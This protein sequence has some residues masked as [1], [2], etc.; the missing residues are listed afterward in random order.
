MVWITEDCKQPHTMKPSKLC[1]KRHF[2]EKWLDLTRASSLLCVVKYCPHNSNFNLSGQKTMTK[3][4]MLHMLALLWPILTAQ[5]MQTL[6]PSHTTI[7]YYACWPWRHVKALSCIRL[8][9]P[10]VWR[11]PATLPTLKVDI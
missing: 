11:S 4:F 10:P 2:H 7:N 9:N 1:F 5:L 6:S 3:L 8:P